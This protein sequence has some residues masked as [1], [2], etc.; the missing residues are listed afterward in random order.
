[1]ILLDT[2]TLLWL[3]EKPPRLPDPV[4]ELIR[5]TTL[6][7]RYVSA[8]TAFE[9][10]VKY[11]K[12]KLH[13]PKLPQAWFNASITQRGL[14][15]LYMTDTIAFRAAGLPAIHKDPADRIIIATALEYD[16]TIIT[17]DPVFS[18]YKKVKVVWE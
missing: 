1:M 7:H 16:L 3:S 2:C 17:I 11:M 5:N 9:I 12:N 13:L 8:I 15:V 6:G 14:N 18:K 10:G 4:I